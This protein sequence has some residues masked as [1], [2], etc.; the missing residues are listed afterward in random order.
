MSVSSL[1]RR[2]SRRSISAL[3]SISEFCVNFFNSSIFARSSMT[4]FSN[5]SS[6]A[7]LVH[8]LCCVMLRFGLVF[9]SFLHGESQHLADH[10]SLKIQ[11]FG[12]PLVGLHEWFVQ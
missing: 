6:P 3:K 4:G 1:L 10:A 8:L 5:S 9:L 12:S 11:P 7:T 2:V